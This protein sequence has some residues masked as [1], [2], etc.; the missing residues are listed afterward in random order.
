MGGFSNYPKAIINQHIQLVEKDFLRFTGLVNK[1]VFEV[2]KESNHDLYTKI[3]LLKQESKTWY[4][5]DRLKPKMERNYRLIY[6]WVN[7]KIPKPQ[8]PTPNTKPLTPKP[9]STKKQIRK[10]AVPFDDEPLM[11]DTPL[12][13]Q[14]DL[15]SKYFLQVED[16][17]RDGVVMGKSVDEITESILKVVD[18]DAKR[19][20]FW[21]EDQLNMFY[22]EQQ[23]LKSIREGY[24]HYV[25][26]AGSKARPTHAANSG[27][28]FSWNVGAD[29]LTRPGARH[30]GEDYRCHCTLKN[31]TAEEAAKKGYSPEPPRKPASTEQLVENYYGKGAF[32]SSFKNAMNKIALDYG[33]TWNK[34]D[35]VYSGYTIKSVQ[36]SGTISENANVS[37]QILID[38]GFEKIDGEMIA[39]FDLFVVPKEMQ[40]KGFSKKVFKEYLD[41]LRKIGVKKINIYANKEVGGYSWARFGFSAKSRDEVENLLFQYGERLSAKEMRDAETLIEKYYSNRSENEPFPMNLLADKKYGKKLLKGSSWK[42]YF[43]LT[44]AEQLKEFYNYVGGLK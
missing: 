38:I 17:I 30:P 14:N 12:L 27:R 19:A 31:L 35:V 43:D 41:N 32:G 26:L 29:N 23:R 9:Q 44:N 20:R 16:L 3:I 4:K 42:G 18:M 6:G 2:L 21:A 33:I 15:Y 34:A 10:D 36:Y 28:I 22:A 39:N 37:N 5:L 11:N 25:W 13:L 24:T 7:S 1:K 40:G 8:L